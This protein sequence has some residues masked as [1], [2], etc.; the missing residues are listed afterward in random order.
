MALA[1][2]ISV[3]VPAYNEMGNLAGAVRDVVH[4]LRTFD[5]FEVMIVNDGSKDG[6]A[7]IWTASTG[8]EHLRLVGH[9]G[10][11]TAVAFSPNGTLLATGSADSTVRFWDLR[12]GNCLR[13]IKEHMGGGF[14]AKNSAGAHS[15]V[16]A[17][18]ARRTGRG[19][20]RRA[21]PPPERR[22]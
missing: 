11:L 16:A 14:G 2:S 7:R 19:G 12:S 8:K 5:E 13:V 3:V 15:F 1:R 20:R 4:A 6:T 17:L 18:L 22:Q 9:T 21:G 10:L